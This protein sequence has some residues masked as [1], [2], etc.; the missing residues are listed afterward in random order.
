MLYVTESKD[1]SRFVYLDFN[2]TGYIVSVKD[3]ALG[4]EVTTSYGFGWEG[5]QEAKKWFEK[6]SGK[7]LIYVRKEVGNSKLPMKL[8]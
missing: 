8:L 7:K 1:Q 4:H 5:L 3:I 6:S 2:Q